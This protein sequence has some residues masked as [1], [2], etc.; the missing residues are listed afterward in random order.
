M[1]K[2]KTLDGIRFNELATI[3][4]IRNTTTNS[5][6]CSNTMTNSSHCSNTMTNSS[7]CSNNN[8][9]TKQQQQRRQHSLPINAR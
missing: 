4:A 3:F 1:K 6:H 7:H 2:N 8:T 5:S 9:G